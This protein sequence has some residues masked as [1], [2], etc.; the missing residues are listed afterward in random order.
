MYSFKQCK[1][2]N[3]NFGF[4]LHLVKNALSHS[5]TF[6]QVNVKSIV[7]LTGLVSSNIEMHSNI[8]LC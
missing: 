7:W 3:Q 1:F 8:G 4:C 2:V 6:Y 5:P